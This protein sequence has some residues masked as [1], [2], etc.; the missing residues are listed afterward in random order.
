MASD[1][2]TSSTMQATTE[3]MRTTMNAI[4]ANDTA[5]VVAKAGLPVEGPNVTLS[6]YN[7]LV[8][9]LSVIQNEVT[10]DCR[11]AATL[12]LSGFLVVGILRKLEHCYEH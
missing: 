12:I 9:A 7:V 10:H 3:A 6:D 4:A 8:I 11:R 2:T 5:E 1:F